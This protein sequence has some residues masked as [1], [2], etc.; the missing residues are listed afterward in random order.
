M[1]FLVVVHS[2]L[3]R[4]FGQDGAMDFDGWQRQFWLFFSD[5]A[6]SSVL[7]LIHSVTKELEAMAEPQP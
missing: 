7:P 6:W 4:V 1:L 3:D 5:C 2:G